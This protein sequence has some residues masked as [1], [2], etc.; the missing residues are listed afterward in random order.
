M[1]GWNTCSRVALF[2]SDLLTRSWLQLDFI[3]CHWPNARDTNIQEIKKHIPCF[4]WVIE[5]R[6]LKVWENKKCCENTSCRR[7]FPRLLWLIPNFHSCFYTERIFSIS[8]RKH[9]N[10]NKENNL[11]TL[12]IKMLIL[13]ACAI[14]TSTVHVKSVFL[15]SYRNTILNQSVLVF[16]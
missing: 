14:I 16:S 11:I 4:Y 5:T 2:M 12:I 1:T 3:Y 10:E 8:F 15:L 13:F 9:G 7:V 6:R